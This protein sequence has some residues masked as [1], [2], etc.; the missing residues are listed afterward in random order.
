MG[1]ENLV[2]GVGGI[3]VVLMSLMGRVVIVVPSKH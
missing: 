2:V 1:V 3:D